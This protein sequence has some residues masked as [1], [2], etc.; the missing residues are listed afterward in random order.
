MTR[1]LMDSTCDLCIKGQ[2]LNSGCMAC[3]AN[4]SSLT[5]FDAGGSYCAH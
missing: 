2:G 3:N 1:K 4:V 5:C